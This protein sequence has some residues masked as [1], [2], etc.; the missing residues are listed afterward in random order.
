MEGQGTRQDWFSQIFDNTSTYLL[1][2]FK[3]TAASRGVA[4][5]LRKIV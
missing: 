4:V 2:N 3:S 1:N 5:I